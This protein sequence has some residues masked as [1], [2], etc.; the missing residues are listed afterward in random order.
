MA[1]HLPPAAARQFHERA[2][3]CCIE[4][5]QY[6]DAAW[7]LLQ[8]GDHRRLLAL[9][10]SLRR[11]GTFREREQS[12]Q[13]LARVPEILYERDVDADQLAVRS[14][15]DLLTESPFSSAA[16]P[17][18]LHPAAD[19]SPDAAA[20]TLAWMALRYSRHDCGLALALFLDAERTASRGGEIWRA[21]LLCKAM[22]LNDL[23]LPAQ[24]REAIGRARA[25]NE[26]VN[27]RL[28]LLLNITRARAELLLG[29]VNAGFQLAQRALVQCELSGESQME[30]ECLRLISDACRLG[31]EPDRALKFAELALAAHRRANCQPGLI[32]G[33]RAK[34]EALL[35]LGQPEYASLLLDESL[36]RSQLDGIPLQTFWTLTVMVNVFL[37]LED[38]PRARRCWSDAFALA[39]AC[40]MDSL[41]RVAAQL[42][43]ENAALRGIDEPEH[44]EAAERT[45]I[46]LMRGGNWTTA[47]GLADAA[48]I[49]RATAQSL[50]RG[51]CRRGLVRRRR[52][53]SV[54]EYSL[55]QRRNSAGELPRRKR[56]RLELIRHRQIHNRCAVHT[57]F[58]A[59]PN[60][61]ACP[62]CPTVN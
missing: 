57:S 24:A 29:R 46:R 16:L 55:A 13:L 33:L 32:A 23:A 5:R 21:I 44:L 61:P 18:P 6:E 1:E 53:G 19:D 30:G 41:A 34:A 47:K 8:C 22:L 15:A 54:A 40:G 7:H 25:G 52:R 38:A 37:R 62:N 14:A 39:R 11:S 36:T 26:P 48:Q 17:P 31:D 35:A 28:A 42:R 20:V 2:A 45:A 58:S 3:D 49:S 59:H 50:L 4:H 56:G 27:E 43:A 12:R 9:A 51:L 60:G 10:E